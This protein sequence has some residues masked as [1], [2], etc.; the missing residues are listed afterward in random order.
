MSDSSS[1]KAP[2]SG[3]DHSSSIEKWMNPGLR[4]D[5]HFIAIDLWDRKFKMR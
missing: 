3:E 1:T 5:C 4:L 2:L